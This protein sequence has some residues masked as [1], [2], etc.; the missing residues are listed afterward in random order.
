M[1]NQLTEHVAQIDGIVIINLIDRSRNEWLI[2]LICRETY[3][4][5]SQ[6]F[7]IICDPES[8]R[9]RFHLR[10]ILDTKPVR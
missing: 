4:R 6:I 3:N 1:C 5:M 8:R 10:G 7:L 2:K 9:T